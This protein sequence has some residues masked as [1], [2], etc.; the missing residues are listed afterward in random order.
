MIFSRIKKDKFWTQLVTKERVDEAL[1]LSFEQPVVIFKH[2]V[3]CGVSH[4]AE[5]LLKTDW[6]DFQLPFYYLDLI[7]NRAVSNYV[8]DLTD[9]RHQSPQIIILYNGKVLAHTSHH[10]ISMDWIRQQVANT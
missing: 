2:S 10:N 6:N 8:A 9:V 1:Q 5:H 3:R 7:K 4:R